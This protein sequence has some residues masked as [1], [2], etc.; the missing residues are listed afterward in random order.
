[1]RSVIL[2]VVLKF[3][4][5]LCAQDVQKSVAKRTI[6]YPP[7]EGTGDK[8]KALQNLM[9]IGTPITG[10]V[11]ISDICKTQYDDS[12]TVAMGSGIRYDYSRGTCYV[13]GKGNPPD[14]MVSVRSKPSEPPPSP[15]FEPC[16]T[17][18]AFQAMYVH[19]RVDLDTYMILDQS[20]ARWFFTARLSGCDIFVATSTKPGKREKPIVIH[21][22]LNG[23]PKKLQ[24]LKQKGDK[25]DK[26]LRDNPDYLNYKLAARV[27]S[28]IGK[29]EMHQA[30]IYF[31]NYQTRH[32][33]IVLKAYDTWPPAEPQYFQF[34][35]H[36]SESLGKWR[37]ILKGE[38]NG[39]TQEVLV[40]P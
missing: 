20:I 28:Q 9:G 5:V 25:V 26:M 7:C 6:G 23:C 38:V 21:S 34:L 17:L 33:G 15:L 16:R 8:N 14:W 40:A 31:E 13:M 19:Q 29:D 36:Y 37:F 11:D 18:T 22:N 30:K 39:N 24:N 3:A 35:G 2:F 10:K 27:Y 1:M 4:L 12:G 32:P